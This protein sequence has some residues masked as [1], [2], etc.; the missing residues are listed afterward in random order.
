MAEEKQTVDEI[1]H[2]NGTDQEDAG[3]PWPLDS[4]KGAAA[5]HMEDLPGDPDAGL[6]EEEKAVIVRRFQSL[7]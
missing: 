1:P 3:N 4:E 2:I 7:S 5:A 6:S